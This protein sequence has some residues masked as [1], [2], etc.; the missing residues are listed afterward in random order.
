MYSLPCRT[1]LNINKLQLQVGV[2]VTLIKFKVCERVKT[3]R[4]AQTTMP[5]SKS[6]KPPFCIITMLRL[7]LSM[8]N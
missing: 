6:L 3:A 2:S 8:L 1:L 4:L 7:H 5:R